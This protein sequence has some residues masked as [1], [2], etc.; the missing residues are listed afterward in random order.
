MEINRR[1]FVKF[2]AGGALG[3]TLSP[4]PWKLT[5][6]IAIWTQNWPWVPVPPTGEFTNVKSVCNLCP[7]GC[8]IEIRKVDNR[9]IKID[10][11]TDYPVNPGGICPLGMGGLQLLYD[12]TI[13]HTH[14]MK[15]VGPKGS[16]EFV[17]ITWDE[18]LNTLANRISDLRKNK[19][20]EALAAV[21]G[22]PVR[23]TMS[24]MIQRLITA[25]G[26][27]NYVRI[28]SIEDTYSMGN[29]LMQG[30]DGPM[31]YDLENSDYI[32]SFGCGL[33]EGWGA[34]GRVMNAWGLWHE[35]PVKRKVK[36][37]QVE[38]RAS[39]TASKADQWVA[40]RPGTDA[41]LAL[42]IAHVIIKEDLYNHAFVDNHSFGFDDW[43]SSD[44]KDHMGFK[45]M[46]LKKYSPDQTAKITGLSPKDIVSLAREFC[47]AK[48]PMAIYGKGKDSLNGGLYAFMAVNSLNALV[49]NLNMPGGVFVTDGVP[50]SPLPEIEQDAITRQGLKKPR[51]DQAGTVKYPFARSL[52]NNLTQAIIE[53][54]KS[55]VDTLLVFSANPVYTLPDGGSFKEA[56][57]KVPFVVSFSPF[58][59]ETSFMADLVLP[60]HTCLEK[61]FDVVWPIGLQYPLYGLSKPV[62]EP[63]YD[64]KNTGDVI[65]ELAKRTAKSTESA[66]PWDGFEEVLEQRAK[67]LFD[68]GKGLVSYNG[69]KPAWKQQKG[70]RSPGQ[71]YK[72]FNEMWKKIKSGG[73]WYRPVQTYRNWERVFKTP[74]AG[75]EFFSSKIELAVNEYA[76]KTLKDTV[77]KN[78][79][80][81]A[82][83][84][85]VFM[86]HY[87]AVKT[88]VNRSEY[89]LLMLPYEMINLA[90]GWVPNPPFLYKTLFDHQLRKD[91]S[92]ANINPGT[93]A[94]YRVKQGDRVIIKSQAGKIQVRV[95]IFEGAMPGIVYLPLGLGHTAYDEFIRGKGVNP[96][97]IIDAGKDPL[98]GDPVWWDTAVKLI[99]V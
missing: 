21:D 1:N 81:S 95:N 73:L 66:F 49:G 52:I 17:R 39:N 70:G 61:I 25:V 94:E 97:D 13:R 84:D 80:I 48:A 30:T 89:P 87:E 54:P 20:P 37:V 9:A 79:G 15:R 24:V 98:S 14:P 10:G 22:N 69:S 92:F 16:G 85:E 58:Q 36:I 77:L 4:L 40:S 50:L 31:A 90:S 62:V 83:G 11:R 65:I 35:D 34:P 28:P 96:N 75:F 63:I 78:M 64:T 38:S 93:A 53:K 88:E 23:S 60:D 29:I 76:K 82:K 71:D 18:A 43:S 47:K 3:A 45:S 56:L 7:G 74:S 32:L 51:V 99:K 6:D 27:P 2:L 41:A 67:G 55:P 8:G 44:G 68:S 57:S 91:E 26:S 42:G 33:L 12:K 59:D 86:P 46:V 5:D 72:S 19:R